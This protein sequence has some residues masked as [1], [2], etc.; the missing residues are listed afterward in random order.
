MRTAISATGCSLDAKVEP[1]FGR[2]R[3][4]VVVDTET[5]QYETIDNAGVLKP[6]CVGIGTSQLIANIKY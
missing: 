3:Y 2:C 4:F 1:H 5:M 6:G